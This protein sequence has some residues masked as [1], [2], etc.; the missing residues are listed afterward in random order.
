M[1]GAFLSSL[2]QAII[3]YAIRTKEEILHQN[4]LFKLF[5]RQFEHYRIKYCVFCEVTTLLWS[6]SYPHAVMGDGLS[7]QQNNPEVAVDVS[8]PNSLLNEQIFALKTITSK[9]KNAYN[10]MDVEWID[11][12][13]C[14]F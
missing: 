5:I 11:I 3:N 12:G 13:K 4:Q 1:F 6:H 10:G 2:P 8:R 9:L 7:N 14:F